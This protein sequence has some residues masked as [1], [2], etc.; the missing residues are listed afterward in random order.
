MRTHSELRGHTLRDRM[1][2]TLINRMSMKTFCAVLLAGLLA[3]AAGCSDYLDVN[4]DPNDPETVSAYLYLPPM[5]H[6]L[7]TGPQYDGRYTGRYSQEWM[8]PSKSISLWDRMG[9]LAGSDADAEQWRDVYWLIGQGL[10]DMMTKA[11]AEQRW[12]LLGVGQVIKAWGWQELTD[13]HGNII[14]KEAFDPTRHTF[15][16]D[17]QDYTYT[18]ID[19]LLNEGIKNL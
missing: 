4:T 19:S 2:H 8:V 3:V 15:D 18:V 13:M 6:W 1:R 10:N 16:Y 11:E 14:V 9:Y 5:L 7:A 17:S 12:D